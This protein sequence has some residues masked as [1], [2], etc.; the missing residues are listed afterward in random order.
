M[1]AE[2]GVD[3]LK[4]VNAVRVLAA[5]TV[6]KANSG[7]PGAPMGCA[8]MAH[9]LW[10]SIMKYNP[11]NPKWSNRD[12]FVLSNGHSCALLY[13]MLHLTGYPLS[14]DDLKAFR[15]LGSITP[16]HPENHITAGVEVSTGPLGQGISNAV[17]LAIAQTHIAAHFNTEDFTVSDNFTYVICG[18]GC[19]QEGISSEASSLAGHL[20]L[21][22]LIVL[23]DDNKITIDGPTDLSFTEDVLKRYEAYGWHTSAVED[24][25]TPDGIAAAVL[26]AK[27]VTDKPSI[28]KVST[29]IGYGSKN[30]GLE[31]THGAP[32]GAADIANVKT[33]FGFDPEAHFSVPED[34]AAFYAAAGASAG[35]AE[36]EWNA[37]FEAYAKANPEKAAEYRRRFAGELPEGWEAALPSFSPE[38]SAIGT[39]KTSGKVLNA[40]AGAIPEVLGGS[41]DLTPSNITLLDMSGDYQKDSRDGRY[42]RFGVREHAM[43]AVSNGMAAYGGL[44]PYCATFLNFCGYAMGAVRVTALSH[45]RVLYIFTHDSI[46]LGEDGPTHQPVEMVASLRATPNFFLFRPADGNEVA[47][48]Y[49]WAVAKKDAPSGFAL[50]RQNLPHLAGSSA[51][52]VAK[53]AYVV[54]EGGDESKSDAGVDLIFVAS[55]SEVSLCIDAAAKLSA[56]VRV[57][58]MP[59]MKLYE[60]QSLEYKREL[61]PAGVPVFSVEALSTFGWSKHAH[62]H[63]GVDAFG[64][65]APGDDAMA[66]F[67]FTV[68]NIAGKAE[69]VLAFYKDNAVPDLLNKPAL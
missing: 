6:Q 19:L 61:F 62:V 41:A 14:M 64:L 7:H 55:G 54:H 38:E 12:R 60:A 24:G 52:K 23:Y 3:A 40:V 57:V 45:L 34:V 56:R 4:C 25:N 22:K 8:P 18:D 65:S 51:D 28:I 17:G 50:S 10:G 1:A 47:G 53:G 21:G 11:K 5:D 68:D 48:S 29:I 36:A 9:A 67:G 59:C 43:A 26:A 15:Q 35:A 2:A 32:L 69:K 42:L 13:V 66:H 27:A 20:G 58:S 30:Q 46:G 33:K 31:K 39:R 63:H 44:I 49:K 16:G 37:T